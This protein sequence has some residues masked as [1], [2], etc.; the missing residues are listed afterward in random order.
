MTDRNL[1]CDLSVFTPE[2]RE[3]HLADSQALFGMALDV[4]DLPDGY[5]VRLPTSTES[6]SKMVEFI[7]YD[8]LC[9]PFIRFGIEVEPDEGPMWLRLSGGEDIKAGLV[10]DLTRLLPSAVAAQL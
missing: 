4:R 7:E 9:C 3:K 6:L 8:R 1:V 5:A 10:D 2:E